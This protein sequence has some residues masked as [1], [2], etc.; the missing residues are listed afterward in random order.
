MKRPSSRPV[1]TDAATPHRPLDLRELIDAGS[2]LLEE[3]GDLDRFSVEDIARRA[4]TS[5]GAFY[6]R[7]DSKD[8]FLAVIQEREI[9]KVV[10]ATEDSLRRDAFWR[11][12]PAEVVADRIVELYVTAIKRHRGLYRASLLR[13]GADGTGWSPMK[14]AN[15]ALVDLIVPRLMGHLPD[16]EGVD[17]EMICRI[18]M[19]LMAGLLVNA[20]LN[21]PGPLHIT[22]RHLKPYLQL[23]FRRCLG[24]QPLAMPARR[25]RAAAPSV[26]A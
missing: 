13:A 3:H 7:F 1:P 21:D 24:L 12:G 9:S 23:M 5:V 19:Q 2:V 6:R 11:D 16:A 25:P 8:A 4:N 14:T 20:L 22:D 26:T 15:R 18:A 17:R 10:N